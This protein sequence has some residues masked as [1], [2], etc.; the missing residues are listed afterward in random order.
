MSKL[1]PV[2]R[3]YL[4]IKRQYPDAIVFF[5][6]GDFY[7]TFDHD[8][9]IAARELDLVLTAR[10]DAPMAGVPF[11]AADNYI[12]KLVAKGYHVAI[13]EQMGSEPVKGLVPRDVV[14]VVTPGTI[15][16]PEYL[17]DKRNNYL[18]AV[19]S[20]PGRVTLW[21]WPIRTFQPASLPPPRSSASS[22]PV[23]PS[24]RLV[25][26]L[27]RLSPA[28]LVL[29]AA[30]EA[31]APLAGESP[32]TCPRPRFCPIGALTWT[33][34]GPNWSAISR[35][36]PWPALAANGCRRRF[37]RPGRCSNTCSKPRK[38]WWPNSPAFSPTTPKLL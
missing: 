7:E 22:R 17:N 38:G 18:A 32:S 6:L 21:Q 15:V 37:V 29:P 2:R 20:R 30:A 16:E 23:R 24:A 33:P 35:W 13:C 4:Q 8:A 11:H 25:D 5:R 34:A 19:A 1:T 9:E 28:E 14:R 12:A 36:K 27:D 26:E 10:N 3:Q 31:R